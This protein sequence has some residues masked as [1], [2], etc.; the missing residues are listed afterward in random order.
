MLCGINIKMQISTFKLKI[1]S[2]VWLSNINEL[3]ASSHFYI[4]KPL[5]FYLTEHITVQL[6]PCF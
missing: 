4:L 3:M 1:L 2:I 5:W 6:T